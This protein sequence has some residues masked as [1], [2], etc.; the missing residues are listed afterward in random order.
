MLFE[1]N[2]FYE[3]KSSALRAARKINE[4]IF[5]DRKGFGVECSTVVD[6]LLLPI[7]DYD[8]GMPGIGYPI[9]NPKWTCV[10]V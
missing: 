6:F 5:G 1:G 3:T 2:H 7:Y 8:G 9:V 4:R 10:G